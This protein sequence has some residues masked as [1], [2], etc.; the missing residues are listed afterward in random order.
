MRNRSFLLLMEQ[1]CMIAVFAVAAAICLRGFASANKISQE[2]NTLDSS[3]AL[4]QDTCEILKHT[5]GDIKTAAQ[6]LGGHIKESVLFVYYDQDK[7][8]TDPTAAVYVVKASPKTLDEDL[9]ASVVEVYSDDRLIYD[10]TVAWQ[11]GGSIK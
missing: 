7:K 9:G 2:R 10:L 11:T 8:T 1:I 6:I 3:V 4:A 5:K